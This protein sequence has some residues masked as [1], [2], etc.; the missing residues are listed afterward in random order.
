MQSTVD[1]DPAVC[2]LVMTLKVKLV[3][4]MRWPPAVR[5]DASVQRVLSH[6]ARNA[7]QRNHVLVGHEFVYTATMKD[8]KG[9][10]YG[11]HDYALY[12]A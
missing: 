12:S 2:L 3:K 7:F 5:K 8:L 1:V 9:Y 10:H 6:M 11:P 4:R